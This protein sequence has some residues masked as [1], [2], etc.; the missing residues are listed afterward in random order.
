MKK[1]IEGIPFLLV[2]ALTPYLF[3]NNPNIAQ[4]IIVTA[5]CGLA[6]YRYYLDQLK[7]PNYVKQFQ[8]DFAELRRE[9]KDLR[10][11]YGKMTV[12]QNPRGKQASGIRW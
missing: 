5:I 3:F 7:Q 4:S 8:E 1:I 2:L 11:K 10:E 6:A 9:N 12:E